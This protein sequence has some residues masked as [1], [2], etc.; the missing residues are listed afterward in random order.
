MNANLDQE[1]HER[2]REIA[3]QM[4]PGVNVDVANISIRRVGR[5]SGGMEYAATG[6]VVVQSGAMASTPAPVAIAPVSNGNNIAPT[7]PQTVMLGIEAALERAAEQAL[8][9]V[10]ARSKIAI[11]YIT[12]P[13]N[14]TDFIAGELEFV[15]V[16]SGYFVVDRSQLDTLRQEQQFQMDGEVDDRT[17]VSIGKV[18]G[19]DII[20]TGRVDGEGNL[21]R[22]RLR[23]LDTE[24]AQVVGAASE[25]M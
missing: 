22:L 13:E 15:F 16:N 5:A 9:N 3:I 20:V 14:L 8:R 25:R 21:R 2:L 19:A 23:V 18:A 10:A 7:I 17:A 24:S 4:Y 12:A 6:Q 11:V 1:A